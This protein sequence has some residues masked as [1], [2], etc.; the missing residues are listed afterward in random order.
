MS[1]GRLRRCDSP[2]D[3]SGDCAVAQ[4]RTSLD[5]L[6]AAGGDVVYEA[7]HRERVRQQRVGRQC[8]DV[9]SDSVVGIRDRLR[10]DQI[11]PLVGYKNGS[12]LRRLLRRETTNQ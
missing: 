5:E 3:P 12:T 2:A 7:R 1:G 8:L 9:D 6:G 4:R 11:A 10:L